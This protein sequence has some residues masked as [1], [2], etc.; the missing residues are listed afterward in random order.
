MPPILIVLSLIGI[1]LFLMKKSSQIKEED[2]S[3]KVAEIFS[4]RNSFFR[5]LS[6]KIKIKDKKKLKN[7]W[8]GMLEKFIRKVRMFFLKVETKCHDWVTKL[9]D[10]RQKGENLNSEKTFS[11][12][13]EKSKEIITSGGNIMEKLKKYKP[14]RKKV[15]INL[16]LPKEEEKEVKPMIG[17]KVVS[18]S[19]QN[20][21]SKLEEILIERIAINPRDIEAYERLGEYYMEIENFNFAKECFKQIMKLDPMNKNV[22]YKIRRLEKLVS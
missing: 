5:N 1:I 19:M 15:S 7:F 17:E 8:L 9:R 14:E 2:L 22:R 12:T 21:K 16:T 11:E 18:A 4:R 13:E 10:R 20:E 3:I 6:E